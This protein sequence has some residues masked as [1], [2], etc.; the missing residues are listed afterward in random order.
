[1][2]V[3]SNEADG[4]LP[5]IHVGRRWHGRQLYIAGGNRSP[6]RRRGDC[7]PG[8][9]PPQTSVRRCRPCVRRC[10]APCAGPT[11]NTSARRGGRPSRRPRSRW[12]RLRG[13]KALQKRLK[14]ALADKAHA[15]AVPLAG[16]GSP[17]SA[18]S[19][20]TSALSPC[21][22]RGTRPFAAAACVSM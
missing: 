9:F 12:G 20:R 14:I 1:M 16:D 13:Q 15:G 19:A 6:G 5:A 2:A 7:S 21:R 18:A 10:Q 3:Q 11:Y 8:L 4:A 17:A 22:R